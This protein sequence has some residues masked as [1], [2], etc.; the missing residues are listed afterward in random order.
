MRQF[1]LMAVLG[2]ALTVAAVQVLGLLEEDPSPVGPTVQTGTTVPVP[3]GESNP[4][5]PRSENWNGVASEEWIVPVEDGWDVDL[6]GVDLTA[7]VLIRVGGRT[8]RRDDLERFLCLRY[9]DSLVTTLLGLAAAGPLA[10]RTGG[11]PERDAAAEA[12]AL[13][14]MRESRGLAQED[15][16]LRL[17]GAT[18][19]GMTFAVEGI[20]QRQR[21]IRL[22]LPDVESVAD[23][24]EETRE[25]VTAAFLDMVVRQRASTR[26]ALASGQPA[27]RAAMD[28]EAITIDNWTTQQLPVRAW[29]FL[30]HALPRGVIAA[31]KDGP[32]TEDPD[33]PPWQLRGKQRNVRLDQVLPFL[34]DTITDE[35]RR[36]GL[37]ELVMWAAC[38]EAL[39]KKRALVSDSDAWALY[40]ARLRQHAGTMVSLDISVKEIQGFPSMAQFRRHL[41]LLEGHQRAF[42]DLVDDENARREFFEGWRFVFDRWVA[43]LEAIWFSAVDMVDGYAHDPS[44]WDHAQASAEAAWAEK[45]AFGFHTLRERHRE[46]L[47]GPDTEG[48]NVQSMRVRTM[49]TNYSAGQPRGGPRNTLY[50]VLGENIYTSNL[51]GYT[52]TENLLARSKSTDEV[53]G[54][55]RG[56]T[57]WWILMMEG[58]RKGGVAATYEERRGFVDHEWRHFM[59]RR[60]INDTLTAISEGA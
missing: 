10:D 25:V 7:D 47:L 1:I 51:T 42:P 54:P 23:L 33:T 11:L 16:E 53:M 13:E 34:E 29:T 20:L 40:K 5:A 38:D 8:L 24:P 15:W 4:A 52:L 45:D 6:S 9:G 46:N 28:A 14:R 27:P 48:V 44:G 49:L 56:P 59:L 36:A 3:S 57:G 39:A 22:L 2:A 17:R 12:V 26:M 41:A 58:A 50:M 32:A 37:R 31:V 19:C 55:W 43:S 60:W 35:D 18:A 21:L 30:D